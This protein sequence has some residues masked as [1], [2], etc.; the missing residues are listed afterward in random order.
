MNQEKARP[1]RSQNRRL[2]LLVTTA[3]SLMLVS[4]PALAADRGARSVG[5]VISDS[6]TTARVKLRLI[7]NPGIAPLMMNVDT[8]GGIV[9]LLGNVSTEDGKRAAGAEAM[10]VSGVQ[11]VE[12]ELEVVAKKG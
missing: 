4:G 12:N 1:T 9:T 5:G 10:K 7:S 2:E 11:S 8:R 6:W 3:A